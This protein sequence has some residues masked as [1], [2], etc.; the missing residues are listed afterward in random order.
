MKKIREFTDDEYLKI[1][2]VVFKVAL[3]CFLAG[4]FTGWLI[5]K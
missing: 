2:V 4:I 1:G 3:V 5:F